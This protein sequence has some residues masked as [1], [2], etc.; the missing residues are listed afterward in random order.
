[1]LA[2]KGDRLGCSKAR[3]AIDHLG[4]TRGELHHR[5]RCRALERQISPDRT[6][7]NHPGLNRGGVDT[8]AHRNSANRRYR[9][10]LGHGGIGKSADQR[11][12]GESANREP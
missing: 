1:M 4:S 5:V 3:L 6:G 7:V 12:S 11:A 10:R 2:C 9:S 8:D